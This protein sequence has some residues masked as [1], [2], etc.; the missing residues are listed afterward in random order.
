M[1]TIAVLAAF[2][3]AYVVVTIVTVLV[4]GRLTAWSAHRQLPEEQT[5]DHKE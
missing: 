2:A 1:H 3:G 4:V 5:E